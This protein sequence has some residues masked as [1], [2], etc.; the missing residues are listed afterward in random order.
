MAEEHDNYENLD[1]FGFSG[2]PATGRAPMPVPGGGNESFGFEE[3]A[4]PTQVVAIDQEEEY[5]SLPPAS[6]PPVSAPMA[7]PSATRQPAYTNM[8]N[9]GT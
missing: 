5:S 9:T 7:I 2:S 8:D 4:D 3:F 1:D 6:R